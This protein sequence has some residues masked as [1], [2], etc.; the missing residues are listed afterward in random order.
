MPL[1]DLELR[2]LTTLGPLRAAW[3]DL[4]A[5]QP[6]PSP[7]LRSWWIAHAAAAETVVLCVFDG[8]DL[9]GGAAFEVDRV[10][11]GRW[12]VERVRSV[13][14][15]PLAPDHLDLIATEGHRR[16]VSALVVDWLRRPGSRIIDLDGLAAGGDLARAFAPRVIERHAAPYATLPESLETYMGERPGKVRSTVGRT[17]RRLDK[18]G[19]DHR[20]VG[21]E[22]A[23]RALDDL[24]R[25]H[26][27]RWADES[28]FLSAWERFRGAAL[29]G[30]SAGEVTVDELV[31]SEGTVVATELDVVIGGRTSFY[32]AGRDTAREWRGGGS[33]L[34][35]R[36]IERAIADGHA[37]YDLLRG[38]EPYKADW[39]DTRREVVRCR[40]GV[41]PAGVAL[42]AGIAARALLI[43]AT[44][45]L[46]AAVADVSRGASRRGPGPPSAPG[47]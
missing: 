28:D 46:R 3:D 41:G 1:V 45:R 9:V 20:S 2:P 24:A 30:I 12:S 39:A 16:Q 4:A 7:F 38:D 21:V 44:R 14:Q 13:G 40:T 36:I 35:A 19:V 47:G 8:A 25:L 26:D 22:D 11:R 27:R 34:R 42:M 29:E 37:E 31:T 33:V 15:G 32:Q 6:L 18:A 43:A 5:R 23:A 10:G 17:S